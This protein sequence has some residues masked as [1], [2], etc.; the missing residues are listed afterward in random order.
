MKTEAIENAGEKKELTP[1][2][3]VK[4]VINTIL[5][6]A[7]VLLAAILIVMFVVQRT[8][9]DGESMEPTLY[10]GENLMVDKLSYRFREP[11]RFEIIVLQPFEN[12]KKTLYIKRI[13]G[14]PG[15]TIQIEEDGTILINGEKLYEGY[16]KEVIQADKRGR[17]AQEVKLGEDE[18]FV[19]GDNRNNSGD[20][21][22][23]QIG[24]IHK[25]QII[26][27]A[28]IRIWPLNKIGGVQKKK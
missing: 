24:N 14:L 15:E 3:I 12:D 28:W 27:R 25:S 4:E 2:D 11:K 8:Q 26:G 5:Y 17:A 23:K 20:S 10:N 16:G 22:E 18:Y 1:K 21:R 13:I 19:M 6:F 9:V 7:G